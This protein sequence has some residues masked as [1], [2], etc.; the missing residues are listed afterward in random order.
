MDSMSVD[1]AVVENKKPEFYLFLDI[2]GVLWDIKSKPANLT[3][4]A[5]I[6]Y[7]HHLHKHILKEDSVRAYNRLINTLEKDHHTNLIITS[8]WRMTRY[9]LIYLF[10]FEG[11]QLPDTIYVAKQKFPLDRV[12]VVRGYL[13]RLVKDSPY[14]IIDDRP[15]VKRAYP[16]VTIKTSIF[17]HALSSRDV[18]DYLQKDK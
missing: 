7:N 6:L 2:D 1:N 15:S 12:S 18:D 9:Q 17:S 5:G 16:D 14:L 13:D 11:L 8:S 4:I 3:L 10:H